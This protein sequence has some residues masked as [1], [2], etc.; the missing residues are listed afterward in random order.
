MSV[1]LVVPCC[2]ALAAALVAAP[3]GTTTPAAGTKLTAAAIVE[4]NVAARGGLQAWRSVKTMSLE[5]KMGAGGNN[6]ATLQLPGATSA[7]SKDALAARPAEEVYLPF[8]MNLERP[9][10]MRLEIQFKGQTAVQVFDGANGWK[11][12]PFLNRRVV[13]PYTSEEMKITSMQSDLDGPLVDYATKGTRVDLEGMEKLEDH[14]TY[15]LKLTMKDGHTTHV[16]VD[17]QT[18]LETKMEGTPR[19]LDGTDHPVEVYFRDYRVV[20][21]LEIPFLLET[22]VLPVAKTALGLKD[23][24][25]PVEKTIIQRVVINPKFDEVK[26]SKPRV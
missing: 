17:A 1:K 20:N 7:A 18:F 5:G 15:K 9:R 14:D 23:P 12:R 25:V 3:G 22:Q 26:F 16:W 8:V 13:E 24:P 10:K 6:R 21:G 4:K 11:L 2:F 19:R